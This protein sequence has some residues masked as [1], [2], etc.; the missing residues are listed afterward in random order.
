MYGISDRFCGAGS[1][2]DWFDLDGCVKFFSCVCVCLFVSSW[3]V[4]Y[5]RQVQYDMLNR[6]LR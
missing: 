4:C 1:R 3:R 5:V 6:V 2:C